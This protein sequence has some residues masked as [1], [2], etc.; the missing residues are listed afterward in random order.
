MS[1]NALVSKL[2]G[3]MISNVNRGQDCP[4]LTWVVDVMLG[5]S[6]DLNGASKVKKTHAIVE[7]D[8][9]VDGLVVCG[10]SNCTHL[11]G[12]ELG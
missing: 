10:V 4:S 8:E 5:M 9:R 1:S 7:N 3:W 2:E 6:K 11:D 12:V